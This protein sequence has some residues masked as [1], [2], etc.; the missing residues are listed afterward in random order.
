MVLKSAKFWQKSNAIG[1]QFLSK[2]DGQKKVSGQVLD[3]KKMAK[4]GYRLVI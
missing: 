3:G 1:L 4:K 2:L